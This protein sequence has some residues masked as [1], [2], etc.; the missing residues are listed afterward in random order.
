MIEIKPFAKILFFLGAPTLVPRI[1]NSPAVRCN[2]YRLV[3]GRDDKGFSL[4][5]G[6]KRKSGVSINEKKALSI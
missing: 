4:P 6:L 1:N 2:L 3:R 5:S